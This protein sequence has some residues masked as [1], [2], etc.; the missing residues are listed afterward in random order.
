MPA[1][2]NTSAKNSYGVCLCV[3]FFSAEVEVH[4]DQQ[5]VETAVC[6]CGVILGLIGVVTGLWFITKAN[7]SCRAWRA[8]R[9]TPEF[10]C[11]TCDR[12]YLFLPRCFFLWEWDGGRMLNVVSV[13]LKKKKRKVIS[14]TTLRLNM[15]KNTVSWRNSVTFWQILF[16]ASWHCLVWREF[17]ESNGMTLS[18]SNTI[19]WPTPLNKKRH[20]LT[21]TVSVDQG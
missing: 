9:P 2:R 10:R 19:H 18:N 8:S 17:K 14:A 7:K 20:I 1:L 4:T 13:V 12:L 6:V 11:Q 15:S 16:F 5:A 21:H 3:F